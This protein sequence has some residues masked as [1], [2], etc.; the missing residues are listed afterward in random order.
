MRIVYRRP[1]LLIMLLRLTGLKP[2]PTAI[3]TWGSTIYTPGP[4]SQDILAHE[5]VHRDQQ[6]WFPL[7]WWLRYTASRSFRADQE[8]EAYAEQYGVIQNRMPRRYWPRT[9]MAMAQILTSPMYNAGLEPFPAM[10]AIEE[11]L[12][13]RRLTP[14][15]EPS[16]SA[17]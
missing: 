5:Q 3:Y 17:T 15:G 12:K 2:P 7:H 4:I 10:R 8:L 11:R 1:W 16:L 13:R 6:G 9:L 14:S